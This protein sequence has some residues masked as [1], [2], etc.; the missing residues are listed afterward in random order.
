MGAED[1]EKRPVDGAWIRGHVSI[2]VWIQ[3]KEAGSMT[4]AEAVQWARKQAYTL[5]EGSNVSFGP[6]AHVVVG[7]NL[8][9]NLRQ[10]KDISKSRREGSLP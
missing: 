3:A 10:L 1:L 8:D 2:M 6:Y 9:A 5:Y 7:W 4:K